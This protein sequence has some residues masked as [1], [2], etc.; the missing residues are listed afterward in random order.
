MN[1]I[2]MVDL[3][4]QYQQIKPEIDTAIAEVL[5]SAAFIGGAQ[6]KQFAQELAAYLG[7]KHVI[8]CANGTDALQIVLMA[9]NFPKGSEI[10]VPSFNYVAAVEVIALMGLVPVFVEV[11]PDFFC[12]DTA[13]IE[14][15]ISPKTVAI[16]PVHLFGQGA[17]MEHIMQIA[18]RHRLVVIEDTA[19]SI[20]AKFTFS[21]GAARP[22]GGI[23]HV[24][25]TSFFPSKNLGCM[26][27]GGAIF[28]NDDAFAAQ[29]QMIANHGQKQK[30]TY[31]TVGINSRLDTIQAAILRVKLKY[32][33][34]YTQ[35]REQAAQCYDILLADVENVQIPARRTKSTHVF[36]Q[37]TLL[38]ENKTV[39][40]RVKSAL[41]EVGVPSMIYYPSPLHLQQAYSYLGYEKG[42][43]PL[44]ESLCERVLSLPMHTELTE[45]Q[46]VYIVEEL[47]LAL[48]S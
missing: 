8:P 31:Q 4:A 27:D 11:E 25:T 9:Y 40:D 38:L 6:V 39:R 14:A 34:S 20:G 17:D 42:S 5:E 45:E 37:Y 7:I 2:Q 22:L 43:L 41:T 12:L 19:Q 1:K 24:G 33:T 44:S 13:Q 3:Q 46:Q 35:A 32:L 28:T 21:D 47:K 30:Y 26:G 18:L 48:K 15:L 16:L 29:M 23:G 36:H 10:I